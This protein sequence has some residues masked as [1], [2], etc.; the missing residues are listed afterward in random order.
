MRSTPAGMSVPSTSA[1]AATIRIPLAQRCQPPTNTG[2]PAATIAGSFPAMT[3]AGG[4]SVADNTMAS[5][6]ARRAA[7]ASSSSGDLRPAIRCAAR[8][9]ARPARRSAV[10]VR[11]AHPAGRPRG[12]E[13][14]CA[15]ARGD[16][17]ARRACCARNAEKKCSSATV[18]SPLP[19]A[20]SSCSTGNSRRRSPSRS[21][22]GAAPRI[23]LLEFVFVV[24]RDRGHDAF[25]IRVPRALLRPRTSAPAPRARAPPG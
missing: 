20:A 17:S 3:P 18:P 7:T 23:H 12:C 4:V 10:R 14:P 13:D 22:A 25:A 21:S 16:E 24:A 6:W 19:A 15:C 11:V 5:Q 1:P 8:S 9:R 2:T